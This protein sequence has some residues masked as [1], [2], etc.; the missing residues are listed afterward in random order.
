MDLNVEYFGNSVTVWLEA[1][2]V[3]VV[4]LTVLR[5]VR[6]VVEGRLSVWAK[7]TN[8]TVDDLIAD[9]VKKTKLIFLM[10]LSAFFA[11]TLLTLPPGVDWGVGKAA[12]LAVL[13]Q[14]G[15]WGGAI[16]QYLISQYVRLEGQEERE[17]SAAAFSFLGKL[18]LWSL[19]LV[20]ALDNLEF[21]ITA[22]V[23]SLGIGGIAVALAVQNILGD[24]FASLSIMLDKP[25]VAGD[26]IILD[27]FAC[28]IEHVGL[29]TTRAR[30]LS[31]EQL[32]F[33]NSD[34]LKSRLRN[35]KRM[36]ERRVVFEIG[37]VYQTPVE[38]V[39]KIPSM[40]QEIIVKQPNTRFDRVHFKEFGPSSLNF[41]IVF[42][43]TQPDY[44]LFMDT[45]QAVN[46]EI[47]KRF[48][49]EGIEFA[50]PTQ[51]LFLAGENESSEE[52]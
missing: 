16:V 40:I 13:Y 36:E 27:N 26:F 5:V 51:T 38:Q 45:R 28:T 31:G 49:A 22:L 14:A 7:R 2:V 52:A 32:I 39:E 1:L 18:A 34:L 19:I 30:S 33:A 35:F 9:L 4:S 37:V 11:S 48:E 6:G 23:T 12:I 42:W 17:G 46:L 10:I 41:E 20:L 3:F 47:M 8:T 29:K 50:Y 44:L 21:D 25:F 24:L 15:V 43:M